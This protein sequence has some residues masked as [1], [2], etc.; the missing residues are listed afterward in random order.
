M[1]DDWQGLV[2]QGMVHDSPAERKCGTA[3]EAWC[4]QVR[5]FELFVMGGKIWWETTA[6]EQ[7][8]QLRPRLEATR[9]CA[10]I[11]RVAHRAELTNRAQHLENV[12]LALGFLTSYGRLVIAPSRW[13]HCQ[14]LVLLL[15]D[16]AD[17]VHEVCY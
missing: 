2:L 4:M 11:R 1:P 7:T 5:H 17:S 3:S 10:Q 8:V 14:G 15:Q 6:W 16:L 12:L 9:L 13:R